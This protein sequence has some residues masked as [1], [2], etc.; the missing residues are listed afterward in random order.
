MRA[1]RVR[2]VEIGTGPVIIYKFEPR[3]RTCMCNREGS[4]ARRRRESRK[5]EESRGIYIFCKYRMS[6]DVRCNGLLCCTLSLSLSLFSRVLYPRLCVSFWRISWRRGV[7][8]GCVYSTTM[9]MARGAKNG[10]YCKSVL[11]PK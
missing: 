10:I 3:T 8:R 5:A 9:I 1:M 6:V 4:K 2:S 11:T 7:C